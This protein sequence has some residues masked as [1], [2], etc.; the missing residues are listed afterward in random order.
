MTRT[1]QARIGSAAAAFF[2]ECEDD[3]ERCRVTCPPKSLTG[4]A[5]GDRLMPSG[6]NQ[7]R[8]IQAS[9]VS[10]DHVEQKNLAHSPTAAL[11]HLLPDHVR[12]LN[13]S[14]LASLTE[15]Q[16]HKNK[17]EEKQRSGDEVFSDS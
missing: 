4:N 2:P 11:A 14:K 6:A 9:T 3:C 8:V 12:L 15:N 17:R 16:E 5:R 13:S 7:R 1:P 10:L